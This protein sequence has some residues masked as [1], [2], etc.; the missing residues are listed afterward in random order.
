[1]TDNGWALLCSRGYILM[2]FRIAPMIESAAR[3]ESLGGERTPRGTAAAV[4]AAASATGPLVIKRSVRWSN[5]VHVPKFAIDLDAL[6]YHSR[7]G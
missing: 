4:L 3:R 7:P 1:L 5:A 2:K 6:S